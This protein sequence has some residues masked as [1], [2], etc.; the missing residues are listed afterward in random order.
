[1]KT[2]QQ[3]NDARKTIRQ[4]ILR[5]GLSDGQLQLLSG[6]LLGLVWTVDGESTETMDRL[7]AGESIAAGKDATKATQRL[8]SG[9]EELK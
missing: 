8:R 2:E 6:M 4:K 3:I 5:E 9:L 1:V 7:L